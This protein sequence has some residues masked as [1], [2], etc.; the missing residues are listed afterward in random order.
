MTANAAPTVTTTVA[1][2]I[3]LTAAA[4]KKQKAAEDKLRR[5]EHLLRLIDGTT[6]QNADNFTVEDNF[7]KQI[8]GFDPSVFSV[9]MLRKICGKLGFVSRKFTKTVCLETI[10]KAFKDLQAYDQL[11]PN[12]NSTVDS[13]SVRCRLLNVIM[14]DALVSCFQ[15]LAARK[16]MAELDNGGAGQDK[17]FWEDVALEFSDYSPEKVSY[18]P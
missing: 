12:S 9:D 10:L 3:P 8:L 13:T 7:L 6:W 5:E 2:N 15:M 11:Q 1:P 17:V 14:S 16:D 4:A 18:E